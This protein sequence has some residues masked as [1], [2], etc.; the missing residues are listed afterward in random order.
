MD[1]RAATLLEMVSIHRAPFRCSFKVWHGWEGCVIVIQYKT[2]LASI[3]PNE[4]DR[5]TCLGWFRDA[6]IKANTCG[7]DKWGAY[8]RGNS[9]RLLVG[10]LIVFSVHTRGRMWMALDK[11]LLEEAK[12]QNDLLTS[13][14]GWEWDTGQWREYKI[15]P[16]KNGYYKP[17]DG[18]RR[19]E[20]YI[21]E[22]HFA[23]IERV[24]RK[25]SWLNVSSQ[26]T[27]DPNFLDYVSSEL[28][29]DIPRPH[30]GLLQRNILKE[31][32]HFQQE[33]EYAALRDTERTAIVNAR[34][35]QGE[36]RDKLMRYW[37]EA[38]AVTGCGLLV[39]ASHIKPWSCANNE[40]RLDVFNG[41]LLVP[42]LDSAFDAGIISFDHNG[43][44]LISSRLDNSDLNKFGIYP[45]L[46]LRKTPS[47]RQ[48]EYLEYH[49]Q[50]IF[51]P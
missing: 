13:S 10:N 15:V 32:E 11:Q 29:L 33:P 2:A 18:D 40:E 4:A 39:K 51:K 35:G 16:S 37:E 46:N 42:N 34:I 50:N 49:R 36:F 27:H 30:Y 28:M 12:E 44:I 38:C 47:G 24:A 41:L 3:L 14:L 45:D 26:K 25:Y 17:S 5:K 9:I 20:P 1:A 8:L 19:I 48:I 23:Y 22:L 43:K 31:L 6:V 7:N 21:K